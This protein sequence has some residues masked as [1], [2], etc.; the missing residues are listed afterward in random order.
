MAQAYPKST[1]VGF[2]YHPQSIEMA[3]Q[4]AVKAGVSERVKFEV[5]KAKDFPGKGYQLVAFFDCLHDMGDPDGAARHV[6]ASLD[7]NGAWMIVEPFAHD[8]LEDNLNPIGR[9]FYV[10]AKP[11]LGQTMKLCNNVLSAAGSAATSES[12]VMGVKAGLNPRI[13]LDV[14][15]ASSGRS[16][17]TEQKFPDAVLPRT[18]NQGFTA[19]LMKKDVDL[20]VSEAKALGVPINVIEAGAA[21]LKLTC[22]ELGPDKDITEIIKPIE[23]RAG[24]EVRETGAG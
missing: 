12:M 17:A 6:L 16:T 10:G 13:M 1:F 15:N 21:L 19:G 9:V 23:Q 7:A 11:G 24:V 8:R 18:F 4:A 2:D 14:I 22:D 3:Q 20:F 5:A